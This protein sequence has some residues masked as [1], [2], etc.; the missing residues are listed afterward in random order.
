MSTVNAG[1]P[2]LVV[3]ILHRTEPV[4]CFGLIYVGVT[5]LLNRCLSTVRVRGELTCQNQS[6]ISS[7]PRNK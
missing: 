7:L 3:T 2:L 6:G 5:H 1:L 4:Y